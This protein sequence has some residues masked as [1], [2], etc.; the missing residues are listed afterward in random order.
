MV[1]GGQRP[2]EVGGYPVVDP[3]GLEGNGSAYVVQPANA[4]RRIV[5]G[6]GKAGSH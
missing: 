3:S 2:I 4:A 6:G 1:A 5:L